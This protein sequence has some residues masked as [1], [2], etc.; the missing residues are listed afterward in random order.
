M[1]STICRGTQPGQG[2]SE[3]PSGQPQVAMTLEDQASSPTL[4]VDCSSEEGDNNDNNNHTGK[5]PLMTPPL[6]P[7]PGIL[8]PPMSPLRAAL[9]GGPQP[10]LTIPVQAQVV[11]EIHMSHD[12]TQAQAAAALPPPA[13]PSPFLTAEQA[14]ETMQNQY[15]P[16]VMKTYGDTAKTKTI[17]TKKY[18]RIVALLRTYCEGPR[19]VSDLV[20][21]GQMGPVAVG[22]QGAGSEAAKFKLWV[23][24]KGFH[25]GPPIGHPD[26]GKPDHDRILY[27]PTGTDKVIQK[28]SLVYN[29]RNCS[30]HHQL[31]LKQCFFCRNSQGKQ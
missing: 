25:L 4:V 12:P 26:S 31:L 22:V 24:S 10:P 6:G 9:T 27:L 16:W 13:P 15:V 18:A 5:G 29:I 7:A 3:Q 11:P 20:P 2:A 21:G 14:K 28:N 8:V 19:S 17:T 23:K 30:L 1:A